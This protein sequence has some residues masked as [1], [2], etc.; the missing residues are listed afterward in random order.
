[1][2]NFI[3][4]HQHHAHSFLCLVVLRDYLKLSNWNWHKIT[5][6][7]ITTKLVAAEGYLHSLLYLIA[8]HF[9]C[10]IFAAPKP[11]FKLTFTLRRMKKPAKVRFR[12][13][14]SMKLRLSDVSWNQET[15]KNMEDQNWKRKNNS[16][17][18]FLGAPKPKFKLTL[19]LRRMKQPCQ[20]SQDKTFNAT[21]LIRY[22]L[23]RCPTK[24]GY[25]RH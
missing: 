20:T 17:I 22:I 16:K 25:W 13:N 3:Q 12:W 4:F 2:A 5:I 21:S 6:V 19:I 1:M 15:T 9:R 11:Q 10:Q 23:A 18:R 7:T 8:W 24:P 14:L